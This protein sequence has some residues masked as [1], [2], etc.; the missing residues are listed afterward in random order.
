M[1]PPADLAPLKCNLTGTGPRCPT[2]YLCHYDGI[3]RP[4]GLY[5]VECCMDKMSDNYCAA[6]LRCSGCS[7]SAYGPRTRCE[8]NPC[9]APG[10]GCCWRWEPWI[11][12]DCGLGPAYEY[13]AIGTCVDHKCVMKP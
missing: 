10:W 4:C 5:G 8:T 13:C 3:C 11:N 2:D 12:K 6:G 9:G 1:L 7:V